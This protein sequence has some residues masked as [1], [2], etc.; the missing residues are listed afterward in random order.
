[1]TYT[2]T[3]EA[4][5]PPS[6]ATVQVLPSNTFDPANVTIA[7]G[8]SVTWVWAEGSGLHNVLPDDQEPASSGALAEGPKTY[9]YT[10]NS[11]GTYRYY[12]L[13]HGS[14]GGVGMSGTVVVQTN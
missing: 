8:E 14:R 7:P 10:F 9:T 4:G 5:E 3:A 1:L 6:G 2:A 13:A 11:P 12:C